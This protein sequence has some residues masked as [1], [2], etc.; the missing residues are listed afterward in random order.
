M[1]AYTRS[2]KVNTDDDAHMGPVQN[3]QQYD[4][5]KEFL[6]EIEQQR[7]QVALS[8]PVLQKS[9]YFINPVIVDNPPE[10]SRLVQEEPF[11][12]PLPPYYPFFFKKTIHGNME[13]CKQLINFLQAQY[14][15]F[16]HGRLKMRL[17]AE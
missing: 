15:L 12:T 8:D 4:R 13:K 2:L 5:V 6:S 10:D 11:G 14:C 17:S 7:F 3:K 16:Y 1:D 9:G